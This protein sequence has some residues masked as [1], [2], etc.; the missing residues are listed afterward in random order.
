MVQ[1][2]WTDIYFLV[3]E[4][5][6]NCLERLS[7]TLS[8]ASLKT[9]KSVTITPLIDWENFDPYANWTHELQ[10]LAGRNVLE[11][12]VI[13]IDVET[14]SRCTTDPARWAQLDIVLSRGGFP[15]LGCV[16]LKVTVWHAAPVDE[17]FMARLRRIEDQFQW[18]RESKE[19]YFSFSLRSEWV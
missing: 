7:T 4:P 19:V 1:M 8:P 6:F 16:E 9:L 2:F 18:L 12:L 17:E 14:N 3:S 10:Q 11:V 13:D 5:N 15:Y